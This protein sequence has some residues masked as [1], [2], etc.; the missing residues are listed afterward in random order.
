MPP[1]EIKD[2]PVPTPKV[3]K[4]KAK[5]EDKKEAKATKQVKVATKGKLYSD[6]IDPNTTRSIFHTL[7]LS[8]SYTLTN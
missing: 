3:S 1:K 5:A 4:P 2:K 8:F 6:L 7:T